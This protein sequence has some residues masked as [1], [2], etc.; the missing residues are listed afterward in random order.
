MGSLRRHVGVS[1]NCNISKMAEWWR[2][3]MD[4]G[5]HEDASERDRFNIRL[6]NQLALLAVG[7]QFAAGCF[8]LLRTGR[9]FEGLLLWMPIPFFSLVI[10]LQE[11]RRYRLARFMHAFLSLAFLGFFDY[12]YGPQ[13]AA[14]PGYYFVMVL[15]IFFLDSRWEQWFFFLFIVA[16]YLLNQMP[17]GQPASFPEVDIPAFSSELAHLAILV[18]M[19]VVLRML[20][21]GNLRFE[22][23]L[24][25]LLAERESQNAALEGQKNQITAQ[26]RKLERNSQELERIAYVASHDLKTPLRN[27]TGFLSL[28]R[29]RF[30]GDADLEMMEYLQFAEDGA[31]QMYATIEALLEFSRIGKEV[32]EEEWGVVNLNEVME[33]IRFNLQDFISKSGASLEWD[34][35]PS[36]YA[37]RVHMISLFQN[38][39]ENGI[40][41]NKSGAPRVEVRYR[42]EAGQHHFEISDNGIG[43]APE[44]H[45]RIFDI[46]KRLHTAQSYPG[47]G[48]GLA[49]CRKIVE[50][51]GGR[52][53]VESRE[54]EGARFCVSIPTELVLIPPARV[55][56]L[57]ASDPR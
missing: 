38:L 47:T 3:I 25:A 8:Q 48:V 5:R 40:K 2:R 46:F 33:T 56:Y 28:I 54:E 4:I 24:N 53:W 13:F 42:A 51:Y 18:C 26:N 22:A 23:R 11:R 52:I 19:M 20:K 30:N 16:L 7:I 35:L 27:V 1:T 39:A 49:L 36:L 17:A 9:L 32:E 14:V 41:Y 37:K 55:S 34:A 29:R 57:P 21:Q 50:E 31:R 12:L 15:V 45:G 6:L 10:L 44:F 43:I